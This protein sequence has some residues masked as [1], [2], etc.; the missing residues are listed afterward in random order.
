[1]LSQFV[2]IPSIGIEL[3]IAADVT[4]AIADS[5]STRSCWRRRTFSPSATSA[6]GMAM[7]IIWSCSGSVN[8]G[9]TDRSAWNVRI[10]S[11]DATSST[12]A[13]ATWATTSTFCVR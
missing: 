6:P 11:P 2:P 12:T 13:S 8:P 9:S 10:M 3:I 5:L 1:M 7:R 4:P